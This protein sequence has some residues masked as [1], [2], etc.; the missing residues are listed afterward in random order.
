M[1]VK[2]AGKMPGAR[3]CS[4]GQAI[5]QCWSRAVALGA[6]SIAALM[7]AGCASTPPSTSSS[8]S[9]TASLFPPSKVHVPASPRVAQGRHIPR[10]GGVFKVGTPYSVAGKSYV[11]RHE[12]D[13]DRVGAA[14]WYGDAFH[15]RKTA[16]GEV[17]NKHALTGAHPTLPMPSYVY[18]TNL[19]NGRTVLVRINDRG[20]Y[21]RGR[22]ID[23]S[24]EVARQ[25]D[26]ESQGTAKVRV[27]YA[28]RAPISGD[29]SRERDFLMRQPWASRRTLAMR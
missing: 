28:G 25:L 20:P 14:S 12:P 9:Q 3:E 11:P 10:G 26:F 2:R 6:V 18:V 8:R 7:V 19:V 27:K 17:F 22:I 1:Q 24:H 23:L 16:N 15:G 4:A 13:Y 29:N 21:S 5:E